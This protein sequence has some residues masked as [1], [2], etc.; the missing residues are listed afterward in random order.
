[1]LRCSDGPPTASAARPK[2]SS[3]QPALPPAMILTGRPGRAR[4]RAAGGGA[5]G[6]AICSGA[7]VLAASGLLARATATTH[8]RYAEAL[9]ARQSAV[10]V[11]DRA[12]YRQEGRVVTSAGS[13]AG[14][15]LCSE[16]V[17][18]DFGPEAARSVARRLVMPAHR[19]G[20][21]AQFLERPVPRRATGGLG[22]MM[23]RVR[24]EPGRA[25]TIAAMARAA[26]MSPRPFQRHFRTATGQTPAGWLAVTRIAH[27]KARRIAGPAPVERVAEAAGLAGPCTFRRRFRRIVGMP[28]ARDPLIGLMPLPLRDAGPRAERGHDEQSLLADR[29]A[30]GAA[31]AGPSREPWPAEGR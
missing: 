17:R 20:G 2:P 3:I 11:D 4:R 14:I 28:R 5:R 9:R 13:A 23:D 25:W 21:Q 19:A 26:A 18:Q 1:M 15:D 8:W 30:D 10:R 24:A 16:I 7:V 12:L 31:E 29:R 6:T 22:P 27:A